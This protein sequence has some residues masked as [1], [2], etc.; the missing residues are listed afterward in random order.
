MNKRIVIT[1]GSGF[2]GTEIIRE[3]LARNKYSITVIDIAPPRIE[4]KHVHFIQ[5]NLLDPFPNKEYPSLKNIDTVIHLAGKNIFGR[6]TDE[7][8]KM[9]YD[10]R[11]IATQNLLSLWENPKYKPIKLISA[12]AVGYYGNQPGVL[13]DE[14]SERENTYFLS[15]V[16]VD[17][18]KEV[19]KA[20]DLGVDVTC[21][22]NGH[23]I[24]A[25]GLLAHTAGTFKAG[26]AFIL[27]TGE[28][29]MPWI[30]IRDLVHI[31]VDAVTR[32]TLSVLNGVC[33]NLVTQSQFTHAIGAHMS[34]RYYLRVPQWILNLRFGSFVK[35]M[36]A[37]QQVIS[38]YRFVK[39]R[40]NHDDI[41]SSVKFH[42]EKNK[43][44]E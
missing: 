29:Y 7:H 9:I 42:L 13:L 28:E 6:F 35:E 19:R 36:L 37:D 1:G 22:R 38:K 5:H 15:D 41:E 17:W 23:I 20:E 2:L 24:G 32:Q 40:I 43:S 39:D 16:V 14:K 30:D 31:Y 25:G 11:V 27:G 8:K 3:L 34:S 26:F 4:H 44:K 33:N 12:S 10:T 18:E 21:I